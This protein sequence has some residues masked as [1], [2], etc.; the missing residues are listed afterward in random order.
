MNKKKPRNSFH[1]QF[2]KITFNYFRIL[3]T[4]F[5]NLKQI[6][7]NFFN[8]VGR[9]KPLRRQ[10]VGCLVFGRSV[11][12]FGL[13]QIPLRVKSHWQALR[14]NF[15]WFVLED[16]E[17]GR[18]IPV[19]PRS[20]IWTSRFD[21]EDARQEPQH[22]FL[23]RRG[24]GTLMA[25]RGNHL[26]RRQ[27]RVHVATSYVTIWDYSRRR[28]DWWSW[29]HLGR[30]RT[31]RKHGHITFFYAQLSI[32]SRAGQARW[33]LDFRLGSWPLLRTPTIA[34]ATLPCNYL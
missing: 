12:H 30:L 9:W 11:V 29:M 24:L 23:Y 3:F 22:P 17:P 13:R 19:Q 5:M 4:C 34:I 2:R 6:L 16:Y 20:L 8:I 1:A 31:H 14:G 26:R 27:W 21:R 18:Q 33:D 25:Q 15:G 7:I 28:E 10:K 32:L